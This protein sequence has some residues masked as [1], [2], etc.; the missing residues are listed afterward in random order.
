MIV[1]RAQNLCGKPTAQSFRY[2]MLDG[3][4]RSITVKTMFRKAP[5]P[6]DRTSQIGK[7]Y[8]GWQYRIRRV[9]EPPHYYFGHSLPQAGFAVRVPVRGTGIHGTVLNTL[10]DACRALHEL[11][12]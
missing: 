9:I 2:D 11:S 4:R 5:H 7:N 6:L 1:F 10:T 12:T 8:S 3:C